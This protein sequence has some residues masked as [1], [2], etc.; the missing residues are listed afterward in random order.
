MN[1]EH[2][3]EPVTLTRLNEEIRE[4]LAS[5]SPAETV[6]IYEL[7]HGEV[8]LPEEDGT[9]I[10]LNLTRKEDRFRKFRYDMEGAGLEVEEYRGRNF[11]EGPAVAA[12]QVGEVTS[13]TTVPCQWDSLGTGFIVYP[14]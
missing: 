4:A 3:L 5:I 2:T 12:E 11:Y 10:P 6:K 7:L 9:V 14:R 13:R 1:A 8:W